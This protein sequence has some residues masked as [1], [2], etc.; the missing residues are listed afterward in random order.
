MQVQYLVK[1]KL[2]RQNLIGYK[3]ISLREGKL[4]SNPC[5]KSIGINTGHK[6]WSQSLTTLVPSS[7]GLSLSL[8][9]HW[10][11]GERETL[12][13]TYEKKKKKKS[14]P[15]NLISPHLSLINKA[16]TTLS[17]SVVMMTCDIGNSQWLYEHKQFCLS[18]FR[19]KAWCNLFSYFP[20]MLHAR[21]LGRQNLIGLMLFKKF[22]LNNL[23]IFCN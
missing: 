13:I 21:K 9:Q 1:I 6:I 12:L 17:W 5:W 3:A 16:N 23:L 8:R 4:I 20:K 2:G 18:N 11:H 15:G 19:Y 7:I 14:Y 22:L 10:W